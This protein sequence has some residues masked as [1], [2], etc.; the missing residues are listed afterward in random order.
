MPP[1]P[2]LMAIVT[3]TP[4]I[5]RTQSAAHDSASHKQT[6]KF[7]ELWTRG[8]RRQANAC[9]WPQQQQQQQQDKQQ[10]LKCFE[11][12]SNASAASSSGSSSD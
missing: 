7:V 11:V 5:I 8:K 3:P 10:Q 6:A 12:S 9:D 1:K 4:G 2:T